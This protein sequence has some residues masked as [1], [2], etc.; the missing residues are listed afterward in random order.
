VVWSTTTTEPLA[1]ITFDDGPTPAYTPR[2]LAALAAAGVRATFY[3]MEHNAVAHPGLLR[4]VL[5]A[6]HELGNHTWSHLDQATSPPRRIREEIVR[7]T[8]EVEQIVQVPLVG[9]RP[10]GGELTGC[11]LAVCAELGYDTFPWSCTRGPAG[12]SDVA[13]VAGAVGSTVG[14]VTSST[15]TTDSA[16]GRSDPTRSSPDCWPAAGRWR[17][18]H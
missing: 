6:G 15:S 4:E 18:G 11:A 17:C 2:V 7:C 3:V 12:I 16:G 1:A 14:R 10:P 9:F 8:D 5:A 13:T